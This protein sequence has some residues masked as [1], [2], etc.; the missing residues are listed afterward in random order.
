M[1]L[2]HLCRLK[3]HPVNT[4]DP[5]TPALSA[6]ES[7][8]ECSVDLSVTRE[9]FP[10]GVEQAGTRSTA[11]SPRE[12]GSGMSHTSFR[13]AVGRHPL[14][15]SSFIEST[16]K[17]QRPWWEDLE[18]QGPFDCVWDDYE[19]GD[20]SV[21]SP[22]RGDERV[23]PCWWLHRC[24][25]FRICWAHLPLAWESWSAKHTTAYLLLM[26]CCT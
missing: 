11:T 8:A 6:E 12:L 7:E 14:K 1:H 19:S 15:T 25:L 21:D 9:P 23:Q 20:D 10:P 13:Q 17:V 4:P 2:H 3:M 22:R 24:C 16:Y 26:H 18:E 5:V